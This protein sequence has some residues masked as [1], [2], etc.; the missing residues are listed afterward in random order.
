MGAIV[1]NMGT[2]LQNSL[3]ADSHLSTSTT[4]PIKNLGFADALF[5]STQ[6]RLLAILFGQAERSFYAREL[7]G[8]TGSGSGAVQ[9]ELMR[10]LQSGLLITTTVGNQKHYQANSQAP[11]FQEL[12]SIVTKTFGISDLLKHALSPLAPNI[13]CALL[14]GS[15]AKGETHAASD[16]DLMIISDQLTLG[17]IFSVVSPIEP[18]LGRKINPTLYTKEEFVKRKNNENP[19]LNKVLNGKIIALIGDINAIT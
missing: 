7:I 2:K 4:E 9:R 8:L 19:F 10:L 16:I 13:H 18:Q 14:Y 3:N 17:E 15:V 5:T 11:I 6:Q 12:R 1:P